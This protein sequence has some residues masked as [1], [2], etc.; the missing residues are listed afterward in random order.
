[1]KESLVAIIGEPNA[2]KS[3][4]L[5]KIMSERLALVSDV[6]GTTRDRFYATTSWNG[7]DFTLIDTA[8]IVLGGEG[9]GAQKREQ[10]ELENNVQAQVDVAISQ[11]DLILYVLDGKKDPQ[12]LNRAV[13]QKLRKSKKAVIAAVNKIDSPKKLEEAVRAYAF[14]GF[15]NIFAVS[16][17]SGLGIG[18]MLD[19]VAAELAKKGFGK[20]L[21]RTSEISA[22]IVGKPNVGKSSIFNR[23][24]GEER[25]VVSNVPGTTRNVIDTVVEY[26]N[27]KIK[28]LDTAGLKRKEKRAPLPDIYAALQTLRAIHR[29]DICILAIDAT[30]G[31]S[32]QDQRVAK[33]IVDAGKG[34]VI[35]A[36]KIDAIPSGKRKAL[37]KSLPD[38]FPFLWW[39]PAVS[40]SAKTGAGI[41]DVLNYILEISAA[42]R[43][44]VPEDRLEKFLRARI[45]ENPPRRLRD[46]KEPK[47]YSLS[48]TAS[49]P[50]AF[51]MLV[52][53]PA[54]ISAQFRKFIQNAIIKELGFWGT[55]VAL[56]LES[57]RG[58][59]N[60]KT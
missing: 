28:F 31:I 27:S 44:T 48:Q 46:Q 34:L 43:R 42:R 17:V 58:N 23:I 16:A 36:N 29:S 3:T 1:M 47:A 56:H 25:V 2:G 21:E 4:L 41:E 38:F 7:V 18:D 10:K 8:G 24:L 35:A 60:K 13:L 22:S 26:K 53:E 20:T 51:L 11:A 40:V 55:P 6:A 19:A 52:N 39:A 57:R 49:N 33:E 14:T 32:Q 30:E 5:N 12:A 50:P 54:A 9:G 59:P 45:K 15:K 37:Q